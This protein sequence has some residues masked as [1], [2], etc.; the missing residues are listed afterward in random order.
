MLHICWCYTFAG[1]TYLLMLHLYWCYT[2]ADATPRKGFAHASL[3]LQ[4]WGSDATTWGPKVG[5]WPRTGHIGHQALRTSARQNRF[6]YSFPN[7]F[8]I[9]GPFGVLSRWFCAFCAEISIIYMSCYSLVRGLACNLTYGL[10]V[11]QTSGALRSWGWEDEASHAS[12][13]LPEVFRAKPTT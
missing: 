6:G 13:R 3:H 10:N 9:R 5:G 1:A 12:G 7:P 11:V 8:H 4:F 2:F